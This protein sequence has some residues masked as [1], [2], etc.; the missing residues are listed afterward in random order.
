MIDSELKILLFEWRKWSQISHNMTSFSSTSPIYGLQA[1]SARLTGS[2]ETESIQC[3]LL[4]KSIAIMPNVMKKT[5]KLKYLYGWTDKDASS[6]LK[7]SSAAYKN[8]V[9]LS[10]MW[11]LGYLTK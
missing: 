6:R 9:R 8:H 1:G 7:M 11:L 10:R 3:E 5:I 4:D 2:F